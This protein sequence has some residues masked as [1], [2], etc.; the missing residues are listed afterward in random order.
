MNLAIA[1]NGGNLPVNLPAGNV[2]VN[3]QLSDSG[4]PQ[5]ITLSG[6]GALTLNGSNTYSGGTVLAGGLLNL[7]NASALGTGTL[8][9][10]ATGTPGP[11][12]VLDNTSGSAMTLA[13][14]IPQNWNASFTFVGSNPLNTGRSGVASAYSPTV[15]V[16][17]ST[18]TV[19]GIVSGAYA[20]TKSGSGVLALAASDTYSGGTTLSGGV[21]SFVNGGLGSGNI[22]FNG[23]ALQWAH[24]NSQDISP[25]VASVAAGQTAFFDTNG[26]SVSLGSPISGAGGLGKLGSGVMTLTAANTYAGSTT[27]GGGTLQV[28]NGGTVGSLGGGAILDNAALVYNLS[29]SG[30]AN[31]GAAGITGAGSVSCGAGDIGFNGSVT[32]GGNQSYDAAGSAPSKVWA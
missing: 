14:N 26:N 9:V 29:T 20:L 5:T 4:G 25:R 16:S 2:V 30:T 3:G 11:V 24:G 22:V 12:A 17:G 28:G 13:G 23:G 19:G 8:T 32:T 18:L 15:T 27:I 21:L 1:L 10:G 31:I 7:G 6:T